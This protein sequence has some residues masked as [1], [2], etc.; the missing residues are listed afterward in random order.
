MEDSNFSSTLTPE[1]LINWI[2]ELEEY[3]ELEEI[4]EPLKVRLAQMKLK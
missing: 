4:E 3:F 2:G 1:D